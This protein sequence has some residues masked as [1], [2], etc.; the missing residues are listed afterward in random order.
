M[1]IADKLHGESRST[2]WNKHDPPHRELTYIIEKTVREG[3]WGIVNSCNSSAT[4]LSRIR[5]QNQVR[6]TVGKGRVG[7]IN[8]WMGSVDH[9]YPVGL[10]RINRKVHRSSR[11]RVG[12]RGHTNDF[13]NQANLSCSGIQ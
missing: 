10:T 3:H 2:G 1:G 13:H 11:C 12:N 7:C 8:G 4:K 5:S 9:K 6:P